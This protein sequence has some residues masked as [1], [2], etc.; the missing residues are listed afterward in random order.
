MMKIG[1]IGM[2][3][4]HVEIF[5]RLID[6]E[7]E[8]ERHSIVIGA[9]KPSKDIRL[10][11]DRV[12][13]YTN[14]I[15]QDEKVEITDDIQRV[16][17]VSDSILLTALDGRDHLAIFKDIAP[18]G[19]PVF[20]DKPLSTTLEDAKEI[21][22]LSEH[23]DAPI[24]SSSALRYT[25]RLTEHLQ[26]KQKAIQGVY[27][28][29]PIPFVNELPYYHWYGVHMLE[30]LFTIMNDDYKSIQLETNAQHDIITIEFADDVYGVIRGARKWHK[31]FEVSIHYEDETVYLPLYE[32]ERSFY[33]H[34]LVEIIK[35]FET[36]QSPINK[37]NTL[38]IMKCMDELNKLRDKKHK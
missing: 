25:P 33:K 3:T 23:Y 35:F 27:L 8:F 7:R 36:R 28:S 9:P 2:D 38:T 1:I 29:G 31:R 32:Q 11:L 37:S 22:R 20:I 4:S 18:H 21:Y 26:N 13:Q 24:M 10:S 6:G 17:K 12:E 15:R 30:T 5:K 14:F 34:L 16:A 19:K